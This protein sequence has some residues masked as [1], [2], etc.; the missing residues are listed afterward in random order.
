MHRLAR[1]GR[2]AHGTGIVGGSHGARVV[3]HAETVEHQCEWQWIALAHILALKC[4]YGHTVHQMHH[5]LF[6]GDKGGECPRQYHHKR[7]V[8]HHDREPVPQLPLDNGCHHAGCQHPPQGN[9]PRG[10]IYVV[11]GKTRA[12]AVLNQS[13][14]TQHNEH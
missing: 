13:G 1:V 12:L 3:L 14:S 10:A 9:K 8:E 5:P 2:D 11:G 6:R 7:Q 4:V